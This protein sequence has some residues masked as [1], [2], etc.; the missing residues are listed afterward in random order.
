M[1][2]AEAVATSPETSKDKCMLKNDDASQT[3]WIEET[4]WRLEVALTSVRPG[5]LIYPAV[6]C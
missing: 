4:V 2:T 5:T 3:Q 6:P 1:A